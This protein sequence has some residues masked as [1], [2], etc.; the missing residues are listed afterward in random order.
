MPETACVVIGASLSS[1]HFAA[2]L[3][4][5]ARHQPQHCCLALHCSAAPQQQQRSR[6]R[7]RTDSGSESE[8]RQVAEAVADAQEEALLGAEPDGPAAG[9]QPNATADAV[10]ASVAAL[11]VI[12]AEAAQMFR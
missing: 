1:L 9:P 5:D 12:E 4:A 2:Q 7:N 11:E 3:V 6:K 10:Q 8:E